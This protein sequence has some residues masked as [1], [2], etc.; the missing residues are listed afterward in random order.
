MELTIK[1]LYIKDGELDGDTLTVFCL[2][3]IGEK[4][5]EEYGQREPS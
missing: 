5:L 1:E 2:D 3:C 4:R